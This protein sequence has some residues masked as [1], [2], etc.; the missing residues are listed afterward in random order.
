MTLVITDEE[1]HASK[2][3]EKWKGNG[4]GSKARTR[5]LRFWRPPLYQLSYTPARFKSVPEGQIGFR[6]YPPAI[7]FTRSIWVWSRLLSAAVNLAFPAFPSRSRLCAA[8]R[9]T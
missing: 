4:R 5:D 1:A 2:L 3:A 9:L 7:L 6:P 8:D